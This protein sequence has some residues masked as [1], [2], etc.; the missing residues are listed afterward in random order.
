MGKQFGLVTLS[1][2]LLLLGAGAG[3]IAAFATK[4][5][6][7]DVERMLKDQMISS[8]NKTSVDPK[9][10]LFGSLI[11]FGCKFG[12][13]PCYELLRQ[14]MEVVYEDELLYAKISVH[15]NERRMNCLGLFNQL[16]CPKFLNEET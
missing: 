14:T 7:A 12:P 8:I 11:L 2:T 1:I 6:E 10:D 5:S 13:E 9:R 16:R 15:A 4:P 3:A